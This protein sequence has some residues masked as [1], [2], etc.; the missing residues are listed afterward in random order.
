MKEAGCVTREAT[1]RF[2]FELLALRLLDAGFDE[3]TQY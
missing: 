1:L 2:K 3:V